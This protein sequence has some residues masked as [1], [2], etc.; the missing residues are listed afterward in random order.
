M[1]DLIA[2][3]GLDC[4]ACDARTATLRNDQA[5]RERTAK[6][7]SELNGVEITPG[8]INCLGCRVDG[9]K[10][11]YCES[12]CPIRRC[13][14]GRGFGTCGECA[15]MASCPALGEV[16]ANNPAARRTLEA[17]AAEGRGRR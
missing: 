7:W 10:T 4:G 11:P 3:C 17:A 8:M 16:A 6:R 12:L 13:A 9:P 5:L 15:E 1:K 2:C 14:R